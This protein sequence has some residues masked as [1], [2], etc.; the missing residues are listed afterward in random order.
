MEPPDASAGLRERL[1]RLKMASRRRAA[2]PGGVGVSDEPTDE[3][4]VVPSDTRSKPFASSED[5]SRDRPDALNDVNRSAARPAPGAGA[6]DATRPPADRPP[7]AFV[8]STSESEGD[9]GG[10]RAQDRERRV[11]RLGSALAA[12][13]G[14][15]PARPLHLPCNA[16]RARSGPRL[17]P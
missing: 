1:A 10:H 17:R 15:R 13:A 7:G 3:N 4:F 2:R 14:R 9:D 8:A 5:V 16:C 6:A 12:L 11:R